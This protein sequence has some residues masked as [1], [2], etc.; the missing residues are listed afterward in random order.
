M[1]V[2]A[3]LKYAAVISFFI[4]IVSL[5]LLVKKTFTFGKRPLY[6]AP[7]GDTKKGIIYAFGKGMTPWEKESAMKHL[8]SYI[9]GILYHVGVF[10]A[11]LYLA[12]VIAAVDLPRVA[13]LIARSL[14]QVGLLSGIGLLAKRI[15]SP[16]MKELSCPDDF[17]ANIIVDIFLLAAMAHTFYTPIAPLLFAAAVLMFLY[18]PLGKIRHCVFFF[19]VRILFGIFYGRRNVF[20]PRA[21]E[22]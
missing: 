12:I 5:F 22:G 17:A 13:L 14:F 21:K 8:P 3:V 16:K 20:P 2:I 15:L 11:I 18:M 1:H 7:A 9:G 6:A 10:A 19:Y 4:S